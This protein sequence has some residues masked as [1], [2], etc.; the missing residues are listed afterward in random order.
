MWQVP[1]AGLLS[2]D[3]NEHHTHEMCCKALRRGRRRN[4]MRQAEDPWRRGPG[5]GDRPDPLL[6]G[7][8]RAQRR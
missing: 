3:N 2:S 4:I 6:P 5:R 8:P 7:R 1:L